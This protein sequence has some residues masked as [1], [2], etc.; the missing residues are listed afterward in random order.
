MDVSGSDGAIIQWMTRCQV[1]G[2]MQLDHFL[3]ED[4]VKE[5]TVI[6]RLS[7]SQIQWKK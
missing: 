5:S 3:K 1:V 2:N 4:R 7:S 6:H